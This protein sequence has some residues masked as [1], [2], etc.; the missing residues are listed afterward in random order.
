VKRN[1]KDLIAWQKAR[2]LAVRVY[3]LTARFPETERYGMT[4]QMRR[5]AVSVLSNISE[6]AA[7]S[8]GRDL[9]RFLRMARGSLAELECQLLIAGELH[10][11]ANG[12]QIEQQVSE[13]GRLINGLI[14]ST[15]KRRT[16]RSS[17]LTPNP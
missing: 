13:V 17:G 6:G 3:Q 16:E 7:R 11:F 14:S 1:H 5:A 9:L 8:S 4:S 10:F 2:A 15:R 12:Q